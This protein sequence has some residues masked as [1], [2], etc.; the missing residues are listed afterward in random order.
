[1]KTTLLVM[2][3]NE[4][5][6]MRTIMPRVRRDWVD[7][8]VVCD[9]GSSDGTVEWARAQGYA[10]HVQRKRG[11]RQGYAEVWP[12]IEGDLVVT[13]S[14]DGNSIPEKI[15][16][17]VAALKAGADMAIASRY[18]DDAR[19]DD[20]TIFTAVGNRVF[21]ATINLLFGG[22]YTDSLVI[23]RGFRKEL[24]GRLGLFDDDVYALEETLFFCGPRA[25]SLEPLMS[26]RMARYGYNVVEI[27]ASEPPRIGGVG[28]V[29][30]ISWGLAYYTQFI[31]EFLRPRLEE[32]VNPNGAERR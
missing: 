7:Q 16:D 24:I 27:P 26:A 22:R 20:D 2:A 28:K 3:L 25:L 9:G 11:F 19:S 6:G 13:F 30:L 18:K 14:P 32:R 12:S 4:I 8:I 5:A 15:P 17:L 1:M 31:R 10:V 23:F 29:H 21:T